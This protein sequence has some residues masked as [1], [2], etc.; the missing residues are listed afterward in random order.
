MGQNALGLAAAGEQRLLHR[1]EIPDGLSIPLS[2]NGPVDMGRH[3][4][5]GDIVLKGLAGDVVLATSGNPRFDS[6]CP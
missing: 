4:A 2:H 1:D 6:E 3:R 5:V